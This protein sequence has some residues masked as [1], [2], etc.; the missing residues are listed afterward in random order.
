MQWLQDPNQ[1]NVDNPNNV[2]RN[3]NSYFRKKK[4]EYLKAKIDEHGINSKIKVSET[5]IGAS[6][7]LRMVTSLR[8][9]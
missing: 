2:R 5:C 7:I 4:K 1:S 8:L 6:V 3:A 9:K